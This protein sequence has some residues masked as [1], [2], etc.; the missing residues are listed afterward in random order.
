MQI[1][2]KVHYK[3]TTNKDY[4][5]CITTMYRGAAQADVTTA[6]VNVI[7]MSHTNHFLK[8][9]YILIAYVGVSPISGKHA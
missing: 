5:I 6:T 9:V 8:N 3:I 4:T 1:H 7:I 2:N